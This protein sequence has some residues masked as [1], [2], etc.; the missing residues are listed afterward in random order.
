[1]TGPAEDE[2]QQEQPDE[3]PQR[4]R[5][6]DPPPSEPVVPDSAAEPVP[7]APLTAE[8][9]E[10]DAAAEPV[11]TAPAREPV[12]TAPVAPEPVAAEA[13][14]EPGGTGPETAEA[15]Q[16]PVRGGR[17]LP[18]AAVLLVAAIAGV[19][20]WLVT[21][22]RGPGDP[23]TSEGEPA[24]RAAKAAVPVVL[25]YDYRTLDAGLVA[26]KKVVVDLDSG[27]AQKVDPKSASYDTKARCFA[28]EFTRTHDVVVKDF[29]VRYKVVAT[30]D[31]SAGGVERVSGDDVTV[32]LY[33]NQQSTRSDR[34]SPL[35]TQARVQMLMHHQGG[36][37]LVADVTAL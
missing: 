22:L 8:P 28:S 27:C 18:V 34:T 5:F 30:A 7:T 1:M 16:A 11:R 31:V 10:A 26:A 3:Q 29:A 14:A 4:T 35:V 9:V 25:G 12:R 32:L 2:V 13:P 6:V 24:L 36:R 23:F 37:W 19:A 21:V 15:E 20:V 33:V 17:W